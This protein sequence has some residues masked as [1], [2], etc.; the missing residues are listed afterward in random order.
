MSSTD[1][2]NNKQ[3]YT[4]ESCDFFAYSW[5]I[6]S[7]EQDV[8]SIRIFGLNDKNENI[9]VRVED[10]TCYAYIELPSEI[11]WT[12]NLYNLIGSAIDELCGKNR[13]Q[14][15][16]YIEKYKLY[17][18]NLDVRGKRRKF[19]YIF[20]TFASE[21]DRMVLKR[22]IHSPVT[23][24]G[25]GSVR[26]SMHEYKASPIL[27]LVCTADI[28]TSGWITFQGKRQIGENKVSLCDQ[29]YIVRWK[30]LKENREK[31]SSPNPLIMSFDIEVNSSNPSRMPDP[32]IP[33]D[34][35]FQIS[36]VF[37]RNSDT[38]T[39]KDEKFL[40]SLGDP[41]KTIVGDD[42]TVITCK[43]ESSLLVAFTELIRDKNPNV[44]TGYNI[45]GFD[46]WYMIE[47]AKFNL[48]FP[49]FALAGFHKFIKA[50]EKK[51]KWS[52]SAFKSNEY[53][54]IDME[55]RLIIDMLP[56]IRRDFKMSNYRLKTVSTY[57][58]GETKDPLSV[59]GIF[60]CYK[61]GMEKEKKTGKFTRKAQKAMGIVGKYC[62]Q[63][64]ILVNSLLK[65]LQT[66]VGL[67]EMAKT[68]VVP[69]FN[70][71]TSGQ[72]LKVFSQIYK[73]CL[74]NNI[75][76]EH[77][78]YQSAETDRYIGAHV[79]DPIVGKHEKVVP[80]DFKSLYPTTIISM[81]IDY[82]TWVPDNCSHIPDSMCNVM[83]WEDHIGCIHDKKVIRLKELDTE[84][85][86]IRNELKTKRELRDKYKSKTSKSDRDMVVADIDKL[87]EELKPFTTERAE[88]KK[89]IPKNPMC[90]KR[91][92]R[93][94]KEPLGV[95]PSVIQNLLDAREKT[96]KVDMKDCKKKLDNKSLSESEVNELKSFINV[97]DKRQLAYKVSA[98]SMYGAMGV[99]EGFLPFM[100]GAMCTTYKGRMNIEIVAKV[101]PEKYGGKLI[102]GDTD[103]NY[104]IFP[105][106]KTARET[107]EYAEHAAKEITKLFPS[108][109]EL[110]F[111][112]AI[113]DFFFI[114]TKKRY[115]Y[116]ASDKE[117]NVS[118]KIGSKGVLLARR[119]N[120]K[121]VRDVYENIISMISNSKSSQEIVDYILS[122]LNSLFTTQKAIGD[123][124]ITKSVGDIGD[125]TPEYF[126]NEKGIEKVRIGVYTVKPIPRDDPN[127]LSDNGY[128]TE[129]DYY[130]SQLQGH[131]QLAEKMR[132]RGERVDAGT[133][134]EYVVTDPT[135]HDSKQSE[136]VEDLFYIKRHGSVVKIDYYYYMKML[137]QPVDQM[138]NV[139]FINDKTFKKDFILSQYK[140]RLCWKKVNEQISR[141][142]STDIVLIE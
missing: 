80:F 122:D 11:T 44:I 22:K 71:Y 81:N 77:D 53:K 60:K 104:V 106:L 8:T 98:N 19:P 91:N 59:K 67:S 50:D 140:T 126:T 43:S 82:S 7:T 18:A 56:I 100:P 76:V 46:F 48:V 121:F 13:P 51:I 116:R 73:Y 3:D 132:E 89:T 10:F 54:F 58:L 49:D 142:F 12:T 69:M 130:R 74:V 93:F 87:M 111:E 141:L 66:W 138:L 45:L 36:C 55:G 47:R 133:R 52:S 42:V 139:A 15:K 118:E 61:L 79:F 41:D 85:E 33:G 112:E 70:L 23:V 134:L 25:L 105:H 102:Y 128:K 113:Y 63:D 6:D 16:T 20:C 90:E 64:S 99:R 34:K 38:C 14:K 68:C 1:K 101:I 83:I 135:N 125:L 5:T 24:Y 72:Q 137:I 108:P 131:V 124:V 9:C 27:Q 2:I 35:V 103:S 84:I 114:L 78:V 109:I 28:P 37:T 86:R 26:L 75:V 94:L 21:K 39:D 92:F 96:R 127:F 31:I 17:G 65:K 107:W 123:F 4:L 115:M 119:D 120:S 129:S 97:L 29:E 95:I 117:G 40:I 110:Q 62:V 88:L 136:K 30:S 32:T 57:F